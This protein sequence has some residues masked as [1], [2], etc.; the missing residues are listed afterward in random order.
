MNLDYLHKLL[1]TKSPSGY[2]MP[3]Q[4]LV[5][6]ELKEVA[7][8]VIKH[9]S[10][11]LVNIINPNSKESVLLS[12]HAD[13]IG[14]MI[15]TIDSEGYLHVAKAGGVRAFTYPGQKVTVVTLDGRH[16]PGV[17]GIGKGVGE[18]KI[19]VS[20]LFVDLGVDSKAEALA[21]CKPGDYVIF[22][23]EFKMLANNRITSRALDDKIG[24]FI[25]S[26]ALRQ[27]KERQT[28][29]GVY[30]LTS[31]GEETT[32]RGA[33]FAGFIK[34]PSCAIIVDVTF[35][36]DSHGPGEGDV[37]L[38]GGP[39][40]CESTIVNKEMN[41]L[42]REAAKRLNIPLQYEIAVGRTCTDADKIYFTEDGIPC[43]LVS[44]PLRYMHSPAEV[45]DLKDVKMCI[46]LIAEFI[47]SLADGQEFNPYNL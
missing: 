24:V 10:G 14:L 11:N 5:L 26:E 29:N 27:A 19:E 45:V 20:D 33:S 1:K 3:M 44:I 22:D 6:D 9:H 21:L 34:K 4:T 17:V 36:T 13:E 15:S 32:L 47:V 39:V 18:K 8:E 40:L 12:A 31:V 7:D 42:L 43:A 23:T 28:K 38:G 16:I 25:T 41:R 37:K 35:T 30:S 2:E 46:D